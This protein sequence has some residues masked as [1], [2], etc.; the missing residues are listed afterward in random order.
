MPAPREVGTFGLASQVN[1]LNLTSAGNDSFTDIGIDT[2][3]QY[4]G[5]PIPSPFAAPGFMRTTIRAP[6]SASS[7]PTIPMISCDH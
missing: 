4:L 1:P 7:W 2:Q 3:Y 6:A 5:D